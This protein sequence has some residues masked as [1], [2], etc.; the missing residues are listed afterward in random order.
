MWKRTKEKR[1]EE[2]AGVTD[3][4]AAE[5]RFR[6]AIV[7]GVVITRKG[8]WKKWTAEVSL[9]VLASV[10]M[11]FFWKVFKQRRSGSNLLPSLLFQDHGDGKHQAGGFVGFT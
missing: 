11:F 10:A 2:R 9:V 1:A 4:K 3:S 5:K 6:R 8:V 7:N